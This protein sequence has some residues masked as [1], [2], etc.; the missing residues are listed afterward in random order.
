MI[1]FPSDKY[2]EVELLDHMVVLFLIFGENAMLFFI[3]AAPVFTST[4]SVTFQSL[5]L[6]WAQ[7]LGLP[8]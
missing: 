2:P 3:V 8:L 5:M 4:R 7:Q 6:I 1:L